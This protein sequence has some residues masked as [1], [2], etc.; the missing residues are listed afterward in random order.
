[1]AKLADALALGASESNLMGVQVSPPAPLNRPKIDPRLGLDFYPCICYTFYMK[2]INKNKLINVLGMLAVFAFVAISVLPKHAEAFAT[3]DLRVGWSNGQY[4]T[5]LVPINE[6]EGSVVNNTY[7]YT[8]NTSSN[9]TPTVINNYPYSLNPSNPAPVIYSVNPNS[10][11]AGTGDTTIKIIGADF[12][13]SSVVEWNN[14]YRTTNFI[15]SNDL[16]A[17]LTTADLSTPGNDTINVFNPVPGGG[18]SNPKSFTVNGSSANLGLSANALFASNGFMPSN[19]FQW[20]LLFIIILLVVII[21]RKMMA[22]KNKQ[23]KATLTASDI[24]AT[25]V[26]LTATG[27][28][29]KE[30]HMFELISSFG[31]TKVQFTSDKN[32]MINA[33]F[34]NLISNHHYTATVSKY[35]PET[36]L[37]SDAGAPVLYFDTLKVA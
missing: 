36:K 35:D 28:T 26:V 16:T 9:A 15:D 11:N 10:I 1:M 37:L 13:P 14:S 30:I 6:S 33:S 32:G 21:V 17:T 29:P 25:S 18:L 24:T 22:N 7:S 4:V 2:N 5:Y 19:L 27:L 20:L 12:I 34:A 8:P 3:Y 23:L 31:T